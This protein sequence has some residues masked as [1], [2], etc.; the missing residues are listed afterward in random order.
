MS[1][2]A[3]RHR[4]DARPAAV[5][6]QRKTSSEDVSPTWRTDPRPGQTAIPQAIGSYPTCRAQPRHPKVWWARHRTQTRPI[7]PDGNERLM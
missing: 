2:P 1:S 7:S 4:R 5:E 6:R 3:H